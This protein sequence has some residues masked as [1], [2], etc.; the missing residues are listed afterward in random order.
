M[1]WRLAAIL[2]A[3][4]YGYSRLME[5]DEEATL[6]TLTSHRTII[7]SLIEEHRGRFVNAAG[8]SVMAEFASVVEAVSCAVDIQRR[9]RTENAELP[10]ARRMEFRIGVN[11]GDVMVEGAQ[12]YG[13]G[14]NVAARLE[15]LAEPGGI[16]V[17]GVV[18]DQVGSKLALN[19]ADL[20]EQQVKNIAKPVRVLRVLLDEAPA[21]PQRSRG[22]ARSHWRSGVLSL[23]GFAIIVVTFVVVQHLSL[24]PPHTSASI[25]PPAKPAL[26]L[27]DKPSIAVLPFANLSGDPEQEYFSDGITDDLTTDLSRLPGLFVIARNSSFT[28]KGK[29]AKLQDVGNELGVKYVLQGSV[30]KAGGQV[31]INVQLADASSGEELWAERYDRPLRDIFALQDEIVRKIVT[32]SNLQ[33]NLAEYGAVIPRST[34]NLEAYDDVLRGTEYLIT[35]TKDGNTKARPMFE[36]AI[37]LD[38]R[39]ATAYAL[40]GV[41]YWVGWSAA[42]DPDPNALKRGLKAEQQ[43]LALDDSVSI[44]HSILAPLYLVG[45]QT[46]RALA[47]AQK[48]IALDPNYASGYEFLADV[49]NILGKAT[50]ALIAIEKAIRLDPRNTVNYLYEQGWSYRLL[51]RWDEAILLLKAHATRYPEHLS[52]HTWLAEAYGGL[53]D[54]EAAQAEVA[55]VQRLVALVPDSAA[56]HWNLA[57]ALNAA[58]RPTEALAVVKEGIRLDPSRPKLFTG[59]QSWACSQLGRWEEAISVLKRYP[60]INT[61]SWPHVWLAVD[62]VELGRDDAARAEVAEILRLDPQF[63]AKIGG[64][65]F[66]ANRERAIADLRKA[67][68]N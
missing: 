61:D 63:S 23:T 12:I 33:L 59:P 26:A 13:D 41:N 65:A 14:V 29:S 16:C 34:E 21:A 25:P 8:D 22:F 62:Y 7:D 52:A 28:Y 55:E 17:S 45:G 44:A 24:K 53:G 54:M 40:L 39:Y 31:R 5:E 37:E 38:P 67:G 2:C 20:G 19:F 15:S 60:H 32:T 48:G 42:F 64:A 18:Q 68:L 50:Q 6:R 9:L 3:D 27:P 10:P 1:E 47:E 11:L 49:L 58:G 43:A 46:E 36:K 51:G 57:E 66:P 56:G 35:L 4:V 30:R